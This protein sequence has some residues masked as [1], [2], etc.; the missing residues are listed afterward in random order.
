MAGN[1]PR[2]EAGRRLSLDSC[3]SVTVVDLDAQPPSLGESDPAWRRALKSSVTVNSHIFN[4]NRKSSR[5]PGSNKSASSRAKS[6]APSP[7][8]Q[9]IDTWFRKLEFQGFPNSQKQAPDVLLQDCETGVLFEDCTTHMLLKD[10]HPDMYQA[11]DILTSQESVSCSPSL[12]SGDTSISQLLYDRG[13]SGG[14][15][16]GQQEPLRWKAQYKSPSKR[17]V[18]TTE[19]ENYKRPKLGQYRKGLAERRA[20]QPRETSHPS[21]KKESVE[22]LKS[23]SLQLMLK[24]GQPPSE[25]HFRKRMKRILQWIF[26]SK[27][28]EPQAPPP[29]DKPAVAA[30]Q[31]QGRVKSRLFMDSGA[32]EAQALM[33]AVGRILEEKVAL[34]HGPHASRLNLYQGELQAP[35][36]PHYCYHRYL[37][38]EEQRRVMRDTPCDH[39]V[40]PKGH[41]CP[42]KSE[43]THHRDSKWAF[44]HREP[45]PPG[46]P[47]W[48]GPRVTSVPGRPLHCPRHCLLGKYTA[49]LQSEQACQSFPGRTTL[50]QGKMHTVQRKTYFSHVSTSSV[51]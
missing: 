23:R 11:E 14:S 51:C 43:W 50:H 12:S 35:L 5:S 13:S 21:Q 48:H 7:G 10:Y 31:S 27:D 36:G 8:D 24:K 3:S 41:S 2:E 44:S 19:R 9:Y 28:K 33:T 30:A 26:P 1:E 34:H 32:A 4:V 37:S 38:Y 39:Q 45:G 40:T 6:G 25:S 20:H 49:S 15:S 17:F 22:S 16:Q 42:N 18:I 46:T 47:Y 29:K